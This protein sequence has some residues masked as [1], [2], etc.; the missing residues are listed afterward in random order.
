MCTLVG[1][2]DSSLKLYFLGEDLFLVKNDRIRLRRDNQN[3][4][5]VEE[6]CANENASGTKIPKLIP[7]LRSKII[8]KISPK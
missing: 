2:F 7:E 4:K 5:C 8:P 1:I 3:R 6:N